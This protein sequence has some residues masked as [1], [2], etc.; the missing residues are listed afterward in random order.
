MKLAAIYINENYLFE[1][2]F[3][4]NF[5]GK[6]IY[7]VHEN[8]NVLSIKR[9]PNN[10]FIKDFFDDSGTLLNVSTIVGTNGV[11]KT[12]LMYEIVESINRNNSNH[13][14]IFE[15]GE[16]AVFHNFMRTDKSLEIPFPFENTEVDVNTIYYSP[17]LDFK[18]TL[19]GVDLSFDSILGK[20]LETLSFLSP[21]SGFVIP[22]E[23]LKQANYK[24]IRNLKVSDLASPIKEIFDFPDDNLHRITFTRYRIDADEY[25]VY[26]ENTPSDFRPFLKGLYTKIK[27]E[28]ND[29]RNSK[30]DTDKDQFI[31]QKN[32]LK[33][34]ILMD[35]FCILIR[36]M[37]IENTYLREG[38]FES[39]DSNNLDEVLKSS[40]A[41]D[42][43]KIW[44][45]DY[46][47]YS[48]GEN[49]NLP[50]EE[51]LKLLTFLFDYI[52]NIEYNS[53]QKGS[54]FF[55]WSL[56]SIFLETEK[57]DELYEL[58]RKLINSLGKYYAIIDSNDNIE[59]R[60]VNQ[61]PNYINFEPSSR[62]LSSGETAMLNLFSRIH[63]YFDINVISEMPTERKYKQYLLLLDEADLGF[64]P[65]WKRH[66]VKTLIEFSAK[67][68]QRLEAKVQIIFTTHD[69][70]TLSDLP[71]TNIVYIDKSSNSSSRTI[72]SD[73]DSQRPKHSFGA[74]LT[75]LLAESFFLEDSL[76]GDFARDKIQNTINW[77]REKNRNI[78]KKE[79]HKRI[80]SLVDEPIL[81]TKLEDMYFEV[82]KDELDQERK[83]QH[84]LDIAQQYGLD[85]NFEKS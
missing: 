75:D 54:F 34:Y 36:L 84:L 14:I 70:L 41:F 7:D 62:N 40:V 59:Y 42:L 63:E 79:Y 28:A 15:D 56:K 3:V 22:K 27:M 18:P 48:K 52:D 72:L 68:F 77:L 4:L 81:R 9:R 51:L 35:V 66:F 50:D 76:M 29:I 43:F 26:F 60:T 44:F 1:N 53:N 32:M 83:K 12:S 61:I 5:G 16:L 39:L 65:I 49:K 23:V 58:E 71:S 21:P 78:E 46:Y 20:D 30:R 45:K 11:G 55:D 17:F 74:N 57:V 24:R 47:Y 37:E 6:Y 85:I 8:Y 33:N 64:H 10:R 82:F 67:L 80:I 13:V 19:S 73:S 38:H 69:A 2:P 25:E 31:L